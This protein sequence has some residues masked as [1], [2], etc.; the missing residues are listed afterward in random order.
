[1][2]DMYDHS[3]MWLDLCNIVHNVIF[4]VMKAGQDVVDHIEDGRIGHTVLQMELDNAHERK[5]EDLTALSPPIEV[6]LHH[7]MMNL[8]GTQQLVGM[9]KGERQERHVSSLSSC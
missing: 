6:A 5:V 1:M 4:G 2:Q 8:N 9:A 3:Y 7:N